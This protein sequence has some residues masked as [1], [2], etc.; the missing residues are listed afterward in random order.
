MSIVI[1]RSGLLTT[2][3]DLGRFG[4]RKEGII[5][6][7]S[8]DKFAHRISNIL[9]GNEE[10]DAVLEIT[11]IGPEL[12]INKETLISIC[13]ANLYPKINGCPIPMWRP[14]FIKKDSVLTFG[15]CQFGMRAYLSIAGSFKIKE[16]MKSKS[17]YLRAKVGGY[18]GRQIEKNDILDIGEPSQ[19]SEIIKRRLHANNN[20]TKSEVSWFTSK[21]FISSKTLPYYCDNPLIRVLKGPEYDFFTDKSKKDL[22]YKTF[23]IT[24]HSDRMGFRLKGSSLKLEEEKSMISDAVS[25]GTIQVPPDGNP[26]VLMSDSQTT[27]GYPRIAHVISVDLSVLSQLKPGCHIKFSEITLEKAQELLIEREKIIESI[28]TAI[29][30][31]LHSSKI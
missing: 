15:K 25:I 7:G 14:I 1:N 29:M 10:S 31:K 28:K 26:I 19:I 27:G 9:V 17:T 21:W 11:V 5:L 30:M 2:V 24:H 8:M 22:F 6:S 3:Q 18:K 16:V 20:I 4:F 23:E 13:G 12:H